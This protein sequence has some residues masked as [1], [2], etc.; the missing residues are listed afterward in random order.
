MDPIEQN[1]GKENRSEEHA[2]RHIENL[3]TAKTSKSGKSALF[4]VGGDGGTERERERERERR[5]SRARGRKYSVSGH[6]NAS[7]RSKCSIEP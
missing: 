2:N 5:R 6:K 3:E 1:G 4:H 7:A